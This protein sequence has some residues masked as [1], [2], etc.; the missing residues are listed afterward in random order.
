MKAEPSETVMTNHNFYAL[1]Q[2]G[3]QQ[4]G[5]KA[6]LQGPDTI[7][8]SYTEGDQL[9]AR[10]ANLLSEA[11]LVPG[12][13]VLAKTAKSPMALL[14]YLACL[15]SG[16][17]YVPANPACTR[18]ELDYFLADA[19]PALFVGD[20]QACAQAGATPG[21]QCHT[22]GNAGQGTLATLAASLPAEHITA[23]N[24]ADDIA[25]MI[26]TSGTTG[27]PKGAMLSHGNLLANAQTLYTS[28]GWSPEDVLLHCLP[29]FHVHGL[30]V[31]THLALLGTS[32][33]IFLPRF[34]TDNV[35]SRLGQATVF[36]GV[37]TYY[38]RL[39]QDARLS[40]D[41]CAN[42][43]LFISGSAPL[44]EET[45]NAFRERTGHTIL[46][47]YGMSETGML[48]S[49]PLE[50]ERVAGTVGFPLTGVEIRIRNEQGRPVAADDVGILQVKGP[51]VFSGYWGKP[52]LNQCEFQDG[53]FI[54]GDLV[55]Q[56]P[57]GRLS[58]V[59]RSKDMVISGGLN[60]YPKEIESVLDRQPGI[61][62]SAVFGVPHPDFG[63]A[64]VAAVVPL[65]GA[66]LEAD[67]L[68]AACREEL[69][70]YKLP[71]H[72]VILEALPRNTMGKVQK[73]RLR[74]ECAGLFS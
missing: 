45:F 39:L 65:P 6:F 71:K 32:S 49:N 35:V 70:G 67:T 19:E 9:A 60:V 11:G 4:A 13:R 68:L 30:F 14:L 20:E 5:T 2:P 26:Y 55:R 12:D 48:T 41:A 8:L 47:R 46:E 17:I 66:S 73:S 44:L 72:L 38:T 24:A 15:R 18:D 27:A 52:K 43:R 10:M 69:A 63:E 23:E 50:G 56:A 1:V 61:N 25:V 22:M 16:V 34:N 28:W 36:M 7:A 62:E 40:K 31:A 58:I 37:P 54:T 51:N 21:L 74:E 57:D 64:V 29:I 3:M 33:M 53:Y 59:G 42:I